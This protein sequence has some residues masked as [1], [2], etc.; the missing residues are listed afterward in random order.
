M[1]H[2]AR[3]ARIDDRFKSFGSGSIG[4]W[5]RQT[6]IQHRAIYLRTVVVR[7]N[8]VRNFQRA[9]TENGSQAVGVFR[10]TGSA[11]P[12]ASLRSD[13]SANVFPIATIRDSSSD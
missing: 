5:E 8:F 12:A 1:K 3:C 9:L 7:K 11:S 2:A 4:S 6:H 13:T 10:I